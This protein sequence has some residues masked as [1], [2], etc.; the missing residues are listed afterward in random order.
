MQAASDETTDNRVVWT[1]CKNN[2]GELGPRSAWERR[3][4]L[5]ALVHDFDWETFDAPEKD[6]RESITETDVAAI[7][8][9]GALTK[10]EAAK[11]LEDNTGAHRATCYRALNPDG[12]FAK[13]LCFKGERINWK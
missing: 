1:C 5:F 10:T 9:N 4:G 3:S 2:D 13:H 8:K 6:K 11:Q 12:R 7:F